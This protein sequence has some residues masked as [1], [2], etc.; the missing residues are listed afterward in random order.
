[1]LTIEEIKQRLSDRNI[2]AVAE[3]IGVSRQTISNIKNGKNTTPAYQ[4]VK[5]IS[6]YLEGNA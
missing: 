4:T 5:A 2:K 6:D 3:A 1:M